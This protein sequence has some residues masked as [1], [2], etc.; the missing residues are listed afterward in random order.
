MRDRD[1]G[2]A[3][4]KAVHEDSCDHAVCYAGTAR[5][6]RPGKGDDER[7]KAH[8]DRHSDSEVSQRFGVAQDVFGPNKAGTPEHDEN[9]RRRARGQI[10]EPVAHLRS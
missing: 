2:A 7:H 5:P 4:I 3:E 9:D 10:F 8:H 1:R 6:L